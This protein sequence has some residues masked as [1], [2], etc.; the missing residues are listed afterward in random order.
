MVNNRKIYS[1]SPM[2]KKAK[3]LVFDQ[4]GLL[5]PFLRC[6]IVSVSIDET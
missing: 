4:M 2:S 5:P 1:Q 3:F 6:K